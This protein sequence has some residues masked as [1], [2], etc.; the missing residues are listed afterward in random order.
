MIE[1]SLWE[2]RQEEIAESRHQA[3]L[4]ISAATL[5]VAKSSKWWAILANIMAPLIGVA[6]ALASAYYAWY[7]SNLP[8]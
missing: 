4:A 6:G 3:N 1:R 5:Q 8:H 2:K 7:L